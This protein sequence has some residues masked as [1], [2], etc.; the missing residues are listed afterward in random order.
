MFMGTEGS[1][2][3]SEN[4]KLEAVYKE[5]NAPETK[6]QEM[7]ANNYL[8]QKI[9]P[10]PVEGA[11]VDVR[12]T[13]QLDQYF[14]PVSFSKLIHQPHL[15]NFFYAVQTKD[16]PDTDPKKVRLNC[17]ADEAFRSEVIIFKAIDAIHEKKRLEFSPA[18][19][20]C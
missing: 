6:W 18:D 17:P 15:E 11:T 3:M 1:L 7:L 14:I 9:A 19:F 5:A 20:E 13:A 12:E 8:R 10:P 2:K 16:L 4:P